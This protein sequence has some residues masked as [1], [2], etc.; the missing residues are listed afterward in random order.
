VKVGY[1]SNLHGN[2]YVIASVDWSKREAVLAEI[3]DMRNILTI[4]F[5]D[6]YE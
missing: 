5:D 1:I 6:L 4:N 2:Q 3:Q